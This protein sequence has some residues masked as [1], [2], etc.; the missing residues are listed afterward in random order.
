MSL[1]KS[2]YDIMPF[3]RA[4]DTDLLNQINKPRTPWPSLDT[5]VSQSDSV[6]ELGC[7]QGWLSNRIANNY[8]VQVTGIDLIQE[9]I[10]RANKYKNNNGNFQVLDIRDCQQK[11][12]T[13]I[14]VGVLHHI[15]GDINDLVKHAMSLSNRYCF[16]GLYHDQARRAMFDFYS[17]Y[18]IDKRRRLFKKMTPWIKTDQHRE[19]WYRDQFEHP[20]EISVT[21]ND[22]KGWQDKFELAWCNMDSDDVYDSTMKKLKCYEFIPGFI[23]GLYRRKDV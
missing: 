3:N 19:S 4:G 22:Y 20:Y 13:V 23:Y 8:P 18:P 7:G 5:A 17:E 21:L 10:D 11:A 2:F 16:I 6:L 15:P 1:V 12:D 9:N 14:S